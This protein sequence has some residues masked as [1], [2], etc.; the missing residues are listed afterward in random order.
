MKIVKSLYEKEKENV[1]FSDIE[2]VCFN[3]DSYYG[4]DYLAKIA[5]LLKI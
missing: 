2:F 3:Y 1:M 5:F 4:I